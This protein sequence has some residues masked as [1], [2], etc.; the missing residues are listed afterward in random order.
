[1]AKA[2]NIKDLS[3]NRQN[4]SL[5]FEPVGGREYDDCADIADHYPK[6]GGQ[7]TSAQNKSGC[8]AN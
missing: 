5:P 7:L 4:E 6:K 1:M 8:G 2:R 3:K